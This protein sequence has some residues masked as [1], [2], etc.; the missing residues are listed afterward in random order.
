V[1]VCVCVCLCVC[2]CAHAHRTK[3][4]F[5]LILCPIRVGDP[6]SEKL[7]T[8]CSRLWEGEEEGTENDWPSLLPIAVI[9]TVPKISLGTKG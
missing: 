9:S 1:C 6:R 4:E 5:C 7:E 8:W 2:A 3:T